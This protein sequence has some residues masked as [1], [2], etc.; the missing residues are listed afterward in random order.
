MLR[1]ANRFLRPFD[2]LTAQ[3]RLF[4]GHGE[5]VEPRDALPEPAPANAGGAF[6]KA[7]EFGKFSTFYE[8]I[9]FDTSPNLLSYSPILSS[10]K[11][12]IQTSCSKDIPIAIS[13]YSII[14][15]SRDWFPN[16]ASAIDIYIPPASP[17]T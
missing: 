11:V 2:K 5:L 8:F 10:P 17:I 1:C 12:L 7:A 9:I 15:I 14:V 3:D 16:I 4:A 13:N 6:Y